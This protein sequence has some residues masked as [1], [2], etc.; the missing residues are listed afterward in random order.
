MNHPD[1]ELR[2]AALQPRAS[3]L[4]ETGGAAAGER[5]IEHHL[6][7]RIGGVLEPDP[8]LAA[9]VQRLA[10]PA[11]DPPEGL[12][13]EPAQRWAERLGERERVE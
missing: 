5:E 9:M 8:Q 12:L 11:H 2:I 6:A 1:G 7:P 13:G 4:D 3:P 10:Q